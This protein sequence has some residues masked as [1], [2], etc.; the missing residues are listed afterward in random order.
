[1]REPVLKDLYLFGAL[2]RLRIGKILSLDWQNVNLE[3]R[4]IIVANSQGFSTK[5]GA[6]RIVP[7]NIAVLEILAQRQHTKGFCNAVFHRE[8]IRLQHSF[9][10]HKYKEYVRRAKLTH[11]LHF[12]SLRHVFATWLVQGG[13]NIYEVQKLPK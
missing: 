3:Q 12:H 11:D 1:M 13:M 7:M 5:S 10:Q 9:A 8:G 4:L 2:S 6:C